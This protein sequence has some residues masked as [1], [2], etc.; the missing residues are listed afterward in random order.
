MSS[1]TAGYVERL[2]GDAERS[3]SSMQWLASMND[4]HVNTSGN[5]RDMFTGA[6]RF[7]G[8]LGATKI[9]NGVRER[10]SRRMRINQQCLGSVRETRK[11]SSIESGLL[12]IR[13]RCQSEVAVSENQGCVTLPASGSPKK[14]F[15]PGGRR[16]RVELSRHI[17]T[18]LPHTKEP[19]NP[20][21]KLVF[22]KLFCQLSRRRCFGSGSMLALSQSSVLRLPSL[23]R[24][25][26]FTALILPSVYLGKKAEN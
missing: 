26:Y 10:Q 17:L 24:P 1:E 25:V 7:I 18:F 9:R 8:K 13:Y 22:S 11:S 14:M 16:V 4:R 20:F 23:A 19:V 2:L 5:Y 12:K 21:R 15:L 3:S 6:C